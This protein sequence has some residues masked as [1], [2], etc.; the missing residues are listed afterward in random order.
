M[1]IIGEKLNGA[2]P[3]V[4]QAIT[5]H[6]SDFIH[7]RAKL[8]ADAGANFIDV[9][10]SRN[11]GE[12]E[13]LDWMID[14]VQKTVNTPICVDSPDPECLV[15]VLPKVKKAGLVNSVSMERN[16][17]GIVFPVIA[18]TDWECIAL[19]CSDKYGIPKTVEDRMTVLDEIAEE[20][21][22]YGIGLSRLHIDPL[23]EAV[24]TNGEAFTMFKDCCQAIREKYPEVHITSGLSNISFGLP[25]R[26]TINKA[27]LTMAMHA[28]MD[29]AI[30]DPTNRD[31]IGLIA[32]S[33]GKECDQKYKDMLAVALQ[34][35]E[36]DMDKPYARDL[37]GMK[38]AAA[39]LN[40][41]DD[42]CLE[43]IEAYQNDEFGKQKK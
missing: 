39:V 41:E 31:M 23:V 3:A 38:Y 1:I 10:A 22:K 33:E 34:G 18:K 37:V 4:Q 8:Q 6:N 12:E 30:M 17:T 21:D 2:I 36:P 16:K 27:F 24:A 20:A 5:D 42:F 13:I 43:Y 9:H 19:L 40:G 14:E 15:K 29:S 11:E 25:S 26:A 32:A 35:A 7:E 28:G